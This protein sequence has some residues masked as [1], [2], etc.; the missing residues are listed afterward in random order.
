MGK[1]VA[2]IVLVLLAA[3]SKGD[4]CE[5]LYAKI[6]S[7]VPDRGKDA[8]KDK[9]LA[10]CRKH[11]DE[12]RKDPAMQCVLDASGDDAVKACFGKRFDDYAKKSKA[13]EA[14]VMLNKIAKSAKRA[15]I[16]NNSFP[17]ANGALLPA[18]PAGSK[19]C[20]GG[21]GG[22]KAS[23]GTTVNNKCPADPEA[24]A[25]DPGWTALEFSVDEASNYQYSYVGGAKSFT[26]YAIG[27]LDC[28]GESATWKLEGTVTDAGNPATNLMPPPAGTY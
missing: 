1:F 9:D 7:A 4:E 17:T 26:A 13:S 15:F 18:L 22:S 2:A 21:K 6:K 3:C 19:S 12:I 28:D 23:P 14:S 20:C 11:L 24:F 16:E 27:D 10:E 8:D 5:R 25:K